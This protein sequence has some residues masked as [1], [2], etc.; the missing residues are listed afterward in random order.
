MSYVVVEGCC[1]NKLWSII[2]YY[3]NGALSGSGRMSS[4]SVRSSKNSFK[5]WSK[6]PE[7]KFS[8][9]PL[10]LKL[11]FW[12]RI[13]NS[14]QGWKCLLRWSSRSSAINVNVRMLGR[15]WNQWQKSVVRCINSSPLLLSWTILLGQGQVQ[16]LWLNFPLPRSGLG[17]IVSM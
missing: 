5:N 14:N 17:L 8:L 11:W 9:L 2:M 7:Q 15:N 12:N 10:M 13:K 16:G 1:H 3:K 6:S 4:Q